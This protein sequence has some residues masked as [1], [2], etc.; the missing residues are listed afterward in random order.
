MRQAVFL[1]VVFFALIAAAQPPPIP[2]RP[3]KPGMGLRRGTKDPFE[4]SERPA[5]HR[6]M[7]KMQHTEHHPK[8]VCENTSRRSGKVCKD[9]DTLVREAMNHMGTTC[10]NIKPGM[11]TE[12]RVASD[13]MAI[14]TSHGCEHGD[15]GCL[16]CNDA[17][18]M[19]ANLISVAERYC[20]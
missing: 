6:Y 8:T 20:V 4:R 10:S 7:T 11:L 2:I 16:C 5:I 9:E 18:T 13:L 15:G 3:T 19:R 14:A 17:G 12:E 1:A